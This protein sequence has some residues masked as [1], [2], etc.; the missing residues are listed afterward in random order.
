MPS[1]DFTT[2]P[3]ALLA[4]VLAHCDDPL[5]CGSTCQRLWRRLWQ[6][7]LW[8]YA[9][10]ARWGEY[11]NGIQTLG[12]FNYSHFKSF[13]IAYNALANLSIYEGIYS[14]VGARPYGLA[15]RIELLNE[16]CIRC[17]AIKDQNSSM[18]FQA[19]ILETGR[20]Q[21]HPG[22][23][24]ELSRR[25]NAIINTASFGP[26]S[27]SGHRPVVL[28]ATRIP[29]YGETCYC[30]GPFGSPHDLNCGCD[31]SL[32]G[33]VRHLLATETSPLATLSDMEVNEVSLLNFSPLSQ[34][35]DCSE[36]AGLFSIIR[37]CSEERKFGHEI[38]SVR[39]MMSGSRFRNTTSGVEFL[40]GLGLENEND[41]CLTAY[42]E[43]AFEKSMPNDGSCDRR[44]DGQGAIRKKATPNMAWLVGTKM[45][46]DED[47]PMG[48][49]LF[50]I[51]LDQ[52]F[53]PSRTTSRHSACIHLPRSG[54]DFGDIF[55]DPHES[56]NGESA[57][58]VSPN[59]T[60]SGFMI[61]QLSVDVRHYCR[62]GSTTETSLS[63]KL[64][65]GSALPFR[66][67]Y[68]GLL[69]I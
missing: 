32:D 66:Q 11:S 43:N 15:I 46:G 51:A 53:A 8:A 2:I 7:E 36:L 67:P 22:A 30:G 20:C 10:I 1:E 18:V 62:G 21:F 27:C 57:W 38:V 39:R 63:K 28:R 19:D 41:S 16:R 45:C 34:L 54:W 4:I 12:R 52:D 69:D 13:R 48:G 35:K 59:R 9:C 37:D 55:L 58:Q 49:I 40:Q 42:V 17:D 68:S 60:D 50:I 29:I 61:K 24:H 47:I 6:D 31:H 25:S 65:N 23:V 26:H 3:D 64:S 14:A 44:R 56:T 33:M 5:A